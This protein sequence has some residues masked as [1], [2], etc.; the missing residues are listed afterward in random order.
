MAKRFIDDKI[1][2]DPWFQNL[3]PITKLFFIYLFSICDMVGI[4]EF[5]PLR[6][7][8]DINSGKKLPWEKIQVSIS[9]KVLFTDRFWIIKTFIQQQ[10]PNIA[11]KPKSPLHISVFNAIEKRCLNFDLNSLSIDYGNPIHSL[12]VKV[13]V[14]EEVKVKVEDKEKEVWREKTEDGYKAYIAMAE[15]AFDVIIANHDFIA[16][17]KQYYPKVYITKSIEKM[18]SE[19]WG[20]KAG[21][22]HC[23]KKKKGDSIDWERTISNGLSQTYNQVRVPY[24]EADWEL[25]QLRRE[26]KSL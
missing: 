13:I 17:K 2:S 1:W 10:Y 21:W 25:E 8:F 15:A 23:R 19:F 24:N 16:E 6:A 18:W 4:W 11:K 14:K 20:T 3:E 7:E 12:Q 22:E 5:N 26:G 9:E